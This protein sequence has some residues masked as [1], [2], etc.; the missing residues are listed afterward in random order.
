M[1]RIKRNEQFHTQENKIRDFLLCRNLLPNKVSFKL[2]EFEELI[3]I[4]RIESGCRDLEPS[5]FIRW[6]LWR[7]LSA[8]DKIGVEIDKYEPEIMTDSDLIISKPKFKN[9]PP[10]ENGLKNYL[11]IMGG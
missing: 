10:S 9:L 1:P 4:V 3:N 11:K 2:E 5:Q 6:L 8:H 7:F